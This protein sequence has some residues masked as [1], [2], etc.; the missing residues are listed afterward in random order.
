MRDVEIDPTSLRKAKLGI[1]QSG[2]DT[3]T[4][5][6]TFVAEL[7]G[8]GEPWGGDDLG[9][10]IGLSYQGIFAA[11]M[12]CFATNLDVIDDY[13]ERL[14]TAA[15]DYERTDQASADLSDKAKA[16]L[17]DLPL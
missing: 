1:G 5:L 13:A 10:L 6:G 15:D 16:N 14:G 11:A 7:E 8:Y 4:V 12:D 17:P 3:D 2:Q 9:S